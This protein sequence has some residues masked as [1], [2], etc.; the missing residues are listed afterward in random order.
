MRRRC[1]VSFSLAVLVVLASCDSHGGDHAGPPPPGPRPE[2]TLS[3]IDEYLAGSRHQEYLERLQEN[4]RRTER[5]V[6]LTETDDFPQV[7]ITRIT[8]PE[9]EAEVWYSCMREAGWSVTITPDGG[10]S[11]PSGLH[12]SQLEVYY[13]ADYTCRAKYP[14]DDN[15]YD[16]W[17]ES[18]VGGVYTYYVESLKPCLEEQGY[19]ISEP[20]T[21][22][23]FLSTWQFDDRFGGY[24]AT[25]DTWFPYADVEGMDIEAL[26][27]QCP[28]TIPDEYLY[29]T[30]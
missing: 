13:L 21:W 6:G 18:E 9:E 12:E 3:S 26:Q 24:I 4:H 14:V 22:P 1:A 20:P 15:L 25:A 16:R 30:E 29:S 27:G 5:I 7:E 11:A 2:R 28:E 10:M 17:G 19:E 23:T 8:T